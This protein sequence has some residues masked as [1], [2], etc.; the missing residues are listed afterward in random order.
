MR[1]LIFW[2]YFD[3]FKNMSIV[4]LIYFKKSYIYIIIYIYYFFDSI[5]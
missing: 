4:Y 1:I 2:K 5:Y 3:I